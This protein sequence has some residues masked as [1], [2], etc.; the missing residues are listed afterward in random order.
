MRAIAIGLVFLA[1]AP[2][3]EE[4]AELVRKLRDRAE[5]VREQAIEAL[6]RLGGDAA[7][8]TFVALGDADDQVREGA[9]FVLMQI[10]DAGLV[11]FLAGVGAPSE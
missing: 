7:P 8:A 11:A 2:A 4:P 3:Q 9:R 10:R 5:G 1:V 6:V